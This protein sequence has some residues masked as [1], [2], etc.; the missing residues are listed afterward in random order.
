M[1]DTTTHARPVLSPWLQGQLSSLLERRGNAP[2]WRQNRKIAVSFSLLCPMRLGYREF[3][4]IMR[5][6]GVL[7]GHQP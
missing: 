4:Q 7:Q 2:F 6:I 5:P 1:T 3:D